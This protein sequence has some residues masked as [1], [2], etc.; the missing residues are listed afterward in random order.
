[1]TFFLVYLQQLKYRMRYLCTC[2]MNW[3]QTLSRRFWFTDLITNGSSDFSFQPDICVPPWN[4]MRATRRVSVEPG[5]DSLCFTLWPDT[6][7]TYNNC[8]R[9]HPLINSMLTCHCR[10]V[11]RPLWSSNWAVTETTQFDINTWIT[12]TD[13]SQHFSWRELQ[14]KVSDIKSPTC[15]DPSW[16][17]VLLYN[18]DIYVA[19]LRTEFTECFDRQT[20]A[21][22]QFYRINTQ[23]ASPERRWT[24]KTKG[25]TLDVNM[26][27][28]CTSKR[29]KSH[30]RS[31][32]PP[33]AMQIKR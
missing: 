32:I 30:Q 1:M 23:Q 17:Q 22:R 9:P 14:R 11:A 16:K 29:N 6:W 18:N 20:K 15:S 5:S 7:K 19:V 25:K 21:G 2:W 27:N 33:K 12:T 3:H 31:K 13:I 8:H 10:H 24:N 28:Y 4:V 26:K